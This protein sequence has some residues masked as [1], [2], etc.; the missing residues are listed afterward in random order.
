MSIIW[1]FLML[2]SISVLIFT[3]P[4]LIT[5]E[6]IS[7][8][9]TTLELCIKLFAIYT[10]WLGLL[11][12]MDK[13]GL[14]KKLSKVLSPVINFL[15][16]TKNEKAKEYIAI[17][18]SANLLGLGNA[19]TPSGIKA[20]KELDE[21][22]GKITFPMIMLVVVNVCCVQFLPTTLIGLRNINGS[23]N[24]SD[25]LL[26]II[27]SSLITFI[28]GISLVFLFFKIKGKRK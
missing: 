28:S 3:S 12:I 18:L 1:F 7:S 24:A 11:E 21:K 15:F 20:M 17:N 13:T 22:N 16:K 4:N 27:L 19:S 26:P 5:S 2:I 6:M 25:I 9:N 8:A 14:S 10:V 23:Q